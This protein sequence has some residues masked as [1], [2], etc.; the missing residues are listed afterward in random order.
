MTP[1]ESKKLIQLT[2]DLI[3]LPTENNPPGGDEGRAQQ[4]LVD[5]FTRIGLGVDVFSPDEI[6]GYDANPAFLHDR[7]TKG[8]NNVVGV[9]KGQGGGR[10]LILASHIDVA[11]KEPLPWTICQPFES[12]ERDGRIY[13]R[14][15]CD[16]K[17]G[18]AGTM[19]ALT[20]LKEKGFRPKG[21]IILQSVVDEEFAGGN[22]TIAACFRGYKADAAI[23]PEPSGL[24]ICAANVGGVMVKITIQGNPGM[25]YTGEKIFNI[26]YAL[27]DLLKAIEVFETAR[28]DAPSPPLWANAVQKREV[29]ITKVK[30]GEVKP[31]GQLG[32]PM[33]A[34][35]EL[36]VQ[37]Y[38]GET[39]EGVVGEISAMVEKTFAGSAV[40]HVEPLYHYIEPSDT[41]PDYAVF[42]LLCKSLR[43]FLNKEVKPTAAPFPCDA[44]AY[45]KYAQTPSVIFGPAGG[46]LHSPDEW[47]EIESLTT[48][49]DTLLDFIPEW[50]EDSSTESR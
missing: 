25:P 26:S 31:H 45:M 10:S 7:E 28:R 5:Y 16:M 1:E 20:I 12:T 38:P 30:A 17:G 32:S 15:S 3:D 41:D 19:M 35:V 50:C 29:V 13:G 27:A 48:F 6:P 42:P 8:R 37:T 46:N 36:S 24:Q 44:F 23:I 47:V 18:L 34:W 40:V 14:G 21:D 22:G 9:W 43:T 2:R 33:D 11:P 49:T 39:V 4:F